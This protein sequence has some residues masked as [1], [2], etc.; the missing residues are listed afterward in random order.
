MQKDMMDYAKIVEDL[1]NAY[2]KNRVFIPKYIDD[3]YQSAHDAVRGRLTLH[4]MDIAIKTQDYTI[5][6]DGFRDQ[7]DYLYK[8]T[9]EIQKFMGY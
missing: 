7:K 2:N 4:Q 5:L 9:H 1:D 8:I 6:A 3:L